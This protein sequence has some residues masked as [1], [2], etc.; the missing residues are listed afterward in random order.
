MK[1]T[2]NENFEKYSKTIMPYLKN[3]KNQN[4]VTI[5]LT[6]G[7]S[8]F[9]ILFAINPTISTIAKLKKEISDSKLLDQ[10]MSEKINNLSALTSEYPK[11]ENDLSYIK[12]AVPQKTDAPNLIGQMQKLAE[13]SGVSIGNIEISPINLTSGNPAVNS[14]NFTVTIGGQ[15]NDYSR[16]LDY[17][18]GMQRALTV[19]SVLINKVQS[20]NHAVTATIKGSAYF[21]K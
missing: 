9:F 19:D 18:V 5:F 1:I 15:F 2:K 4:Y 6:I 10:K 17:L 12:D 20:D 13:E 14:F 3:T 11:I 8:I 21:K 16:F 7:A